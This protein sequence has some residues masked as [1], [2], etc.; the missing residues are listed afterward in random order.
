MQKNAILLIALIS[1][2][3]LE[4]PVNGMYL[5]ETE[6]EDFFQH[7]LE[8]R[9]NATHPTTDDVV[10]FRSGRVKATPLTETA[11]E[12]SVPPVRRN[13]QRQLENP[14][15]AMYLTETELEDFFQHQLESR[16]NAT[17]P[18][19]DDVVKFRSG[20]VKATHL[21]ETASEDSVPPVRRFQHQLGSRVKATHLTEIASEDSVPP[22]RRNSQRQLGSRVKATHLTETAS[23]DS[24]PPVYR[25][26]QRQLGSRI[27]ATDPTKTED[28]NLEIRRSNSQH[29]LGRRINATHPTKTED[30]NLEIRRHNSQHE[31]GRRINARYPKHPTTDDVVKFISNSF[32]AKYGPN[33]PQLT[34]LT[35]TTLETAS[36]CWKLESIYARYQNVTNKLYASRGASVIY[37]AEQSSDTKHTF[38]IYTAP[39]S[40]GK[41][42]SPMTFTFGKEQ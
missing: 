21:T 1:I 39:Y 35:S 8:S 36:G 24:V 12:D 23:E 9:T 34:D 6:L 22:V 5:T 29:Q 16:T 27:N 20:R 2:Y 11:S 3:V 30:K 13:S 18:T 32:P 26:A 15:N 28:K 41:N 33:V 17:H 25:K 40:L 19:T 14:V 38:E 37:S 4:S 31:L 42:S 7:Q 10:K